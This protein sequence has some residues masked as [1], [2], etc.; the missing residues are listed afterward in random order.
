MPTPKTLLDA[1]DDDIAASTRQVALYETQLADARTALA[2]AEAARATAE[3]DY[4][5]A[6][7]ALRK[8][9]DDAAAATIPADRI[10][11]LREAGRRTGTVH[12]A[13][14]ALLDARLAAARTAAAAESRQEA[15]AAA[16]AAG[17]AA[18]A[19]RAALLTAHAQRQAW[20]TALAAAPLSALRTTA[21]DLA[22]PTKEPLKSAVFRWEAELPQELRT[23]AEENHRTAWKRASRAGQTVKT[24]EGLIAD[25]LGAQGGLD[26][27]TSKAA[28]GFATA[29]RALREYATGAELRVARGL[30]IFQRVAGTAVASASQ[31]TELSDT[32]FSADAKPGADAVSQRAPKVRDLEDADQALADA[33]LTKQVTDP[34]RAVPD[35]AVTTERGAVT[36]AQ[37]ALNGIAPPTT[38]QRNAL[39]EWTAQLPDAPWTVLVDFLN[40]RRDLEALASLDPATIRSD[41]TTA[42]DALATAMIAEANGARSLA[43]LRAELAL[44]ER[45]RT[46]VDAARDAMATSAARCDV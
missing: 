3:S 22:D 36:T 19:R 45:V 41:F 14:G 4:E 15:L 1:A 33:R 18:S 5:A 12:N 44:R 9:L 34:T 43:M 17:V 30:S 38:A 11:R 23:A 35:S 39:L 40:A 6:Q 21:R 25:T 29:E 27:A 8:A 7:R 26:A 28:I 24:A 42:E 46:A 31:R 20:L 10:A 16:T 2:N 13:F 32:R 37:T